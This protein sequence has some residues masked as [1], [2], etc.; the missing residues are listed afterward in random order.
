MRVLEASGRFP[1]L[2]PRRESNALQVKPYHFP[3]PRPYPVRG[4]TDSRGLIDEHD[5]V[6]AKTPRS[7]GSRDVGLWARVRRR[8]KRDSEGITLDLADGVGDCR[9]IRFGRVRVP[10]GQC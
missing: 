5:R 1:A 2:P 6:A 9:P 7:L 3:W 4:R 8:P 10:Q